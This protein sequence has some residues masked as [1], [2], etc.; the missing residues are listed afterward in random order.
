MVAARAAVLLVDRQAEEADLAEFLDEGTVHFL[1]TVP[2]HDVRRDL[3]VHEVPGEAADGGLLLA[4][5]QVHCRVT[6]QTVA[7]TR[8]VAME[9]PGVAAAVH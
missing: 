8:T 6:P 5:L 4:E 1:R 3:A 2:L 9:A 7:I